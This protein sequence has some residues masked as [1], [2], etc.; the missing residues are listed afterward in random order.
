MRAC[1]SVVLGRCAYR[2]YGCARGGQGSVRTRRRGDSL[3]LVVALRRRRDPDHQPS[4]VVT[5]VLVLA[6]S[7]GAVLGLGGG[8]YAAVADRASNRSGDEWVGIGVALGL[9]AGALG[10][11]ILLGALAVLIVRRRR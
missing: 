3:V 4:A 9:A 7:G 8:L 11:I 2:V 5:V 1:R 10:A 6:A